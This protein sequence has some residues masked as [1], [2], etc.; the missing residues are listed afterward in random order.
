MDWLAQ[1]VP[2]NVEDADEQF[3]R[4]YLGK[5]LFSGDDV[6]KKTNVLS[7]GEKVRC[8]ISRMML[9]K[10]QCYF[11]WMSLPTTSIWKA[12]RHSTRIWSTLKVWCC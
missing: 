3:L 1:F 11:N 9:Q 12:F 10:S 8:M 2:A 6:M 7:G 5:M 4:G